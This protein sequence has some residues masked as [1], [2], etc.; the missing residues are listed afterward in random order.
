MQ[1]WLLTIS[2]DFPQHWDYTV[3]HGLWDMITPRNIKAG[4]V[5]YF[6]QSGKS[7]LGKVRALTDATPIDPHT[8]TP[9]PW[10]D[11]PG[12]AE[13]PYAARFSLEVLASE[14]VGDPSWHEVA[15]A[16]GLS[17]NP[18]FVRTITPSQQEILDSYI[19]AGMTPEGALSDEERRKVFDNLDVDMRVQRLQLVALRQGQPKFRADLLKAYG[20]R[21]AISGTAVEAVLEAAHIA[22]FKGEHTNFTANGLLLRADLH[23]LFDLYLITVEASTHRVR[24]S[25]AL[26]QTD[27]ASYEGVT[28]STPSTLDDQPLADQLQRHNDECAW[29]A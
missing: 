6:W 11:W 7:F 19:G 4:D 16:T 12:P 18:T 9:G 10:D 2:K 15:A 20:R 22:P 3:Q 29:L 26:G 17:R 8:V 23:T 13:K 5:V 21:C 25:P 24:V 1:A 27:Y 28:I 14:S